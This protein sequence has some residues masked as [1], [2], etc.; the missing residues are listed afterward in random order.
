[1]KSLLFFMPDLNG[2]GAEKALIELLKLIDYTKY[3]VDLF[4]EFRSGPYISEVP[5]Q[6][7]VMHIYGTRK[8][9]HRV[10]RKL[11]KLLHLN[12]TYHRLFTKR[13]I[14]KIVKPRYDAIISFLEGKALK[15]HISVIERTN[16]N[17]TWVHC[18]LQNMHWTLK[19]YAIKE[20]EEYSFYKEMN[21]IVFVSENAQIALNNIYKL[22]K[23]KQIVI[24]NPINREEI[25]TLAN[26]QTIPK[27]KFTLCTVGRLTQAKGYDRLLRVTQRLASEGYDFDVWIIGI[28]EL[29]SYLTGLA[30]K[31][32][33]EAMVHF[34]GFIRP[35]YPFIKAADVFI[36][37]S[38][39]EGFSLVIGEALCIG[40]T[41]ISTKTA[42]A[43]ELLQEGK[44]GL[45]VNHDEDSIY[46]AIKTVINNPSLLNEYNRKSAL[47]GIEIS[48]KDEFIKSFY[49]LLEIQ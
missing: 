4:L 47:R 5:K 48:N 12:N 10:C 16:N 9:Y 18:D 23:S 49:S 40:K 15:N 24:H 19:E 28:G 25:I 33:I 2:G 38:T 13:R 26:S 29:K 7:N 39:A 1:M 37:T 45:L 46:C 14:R 17:I 32:D 3:K 42:G 22:D 21:Q 35:P 41:V 6:V 11:L 27:R 44:Y 36:S 8:F 34:L 31:L 30:K 43:V 20:A